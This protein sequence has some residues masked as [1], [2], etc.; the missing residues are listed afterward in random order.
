MQTFMKSSADFDEIFK[1]VENYH[2][3]VMISIFKGTFMSKETLEK[4]YKQLVASEL[5]KYD[6]KIK[7]Q[8]QAKLAKE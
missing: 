4:E 5:E 3:K 8:A 2:Q 6:N 1:V 7:E